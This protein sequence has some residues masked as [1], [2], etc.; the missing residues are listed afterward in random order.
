VF[1]VAFFCAR[2]TESAGIYPGLSTQ[3]ISADMLESN[4]FNAALYQ[5]DQKPALLS[6]NVVL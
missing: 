6:V 4:A 3:S 5:Y 2:Q 1:Q